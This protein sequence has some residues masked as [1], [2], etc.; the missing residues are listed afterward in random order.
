MKAFPRSFPLR[1]LKLLVATVGF[2]ASLASALPP[3]LPA[4]NQT[5]TGQQLT[6]KLT[7]FDLL[8]DDI[9]AAKQFYGAVFGWTFADAPGANGKFSVI[10]I[11]NERIGGIFQRDKPA[12]T[13]PTTRWL[14]FISVPD[15]AAAAHYTKSHGGKVISG[16]TSVP[17]R[18]THVVM[19][20]PQGALFAV[21]KSDSGDPID[22]PA[23]PGEILWAD[24]F[25][26]KPA[27][28]AAFYRGLV[29]WDSE[30]KDT[31]G[32]AEHLV[33]RCAGFSRAGIT[34]LPPG[35]TQPGW[36]PYVQVANVPATLKRVTN[37]GG[38]V[39]M[40]PSRD[41]LD[42]RLAVISDPKGGVIGVVNW[43]GSAKT[44]SRK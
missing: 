16:P 22:D 2:T 3:K 27:E 12:K 10:S 23:Q 35:A 1:L 30:Q 31:R 21:L 14:T 19:R 17:E 40:P 7:W 18:G 9:G 20:D 42:G 28:A 36:L 37:A 6:G 13:G 38:K 44:G 25:V 41:V 39:L 24:L 32:A 11:G 5:P 4:I 29:G 26:P 33:V 34:M 8:T 15:A 43:T